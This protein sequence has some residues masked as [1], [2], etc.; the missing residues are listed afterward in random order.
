MGRRWG[1]EE[2]FSR[3]SLP[4]YSAGGPCEQ[5]WHGRFVLSLRLSVQHFPCDHGVARPPRYP[6][7]WFWRGCRGVCHAKTTQVPVSSSRVPCCKHCRSVLGLA[8]VADTSQHDSQVLK[9][10]QKATVLRVSC[11]NKRPKIAFTL[12]TSLCAHQ[13]SLSPATKASLWPIFNELGHGRSQDRKRGWGVQRNE[14]LRRIFLS[15]AP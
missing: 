8:A 10:Q 9:P 3:D 7:G 2:Q 12:R 13:G 14:S 6:E 4:I 15:S 1:H 11:S 5:F